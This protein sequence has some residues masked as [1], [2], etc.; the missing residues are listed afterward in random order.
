[1]IIEHANTK[2]N[3]VTTKQIFKQR[4]SVITHADTISFKHAIFKFILKGRFE[5]C[6]WDIELWGKWKDISLSYLLD[7]RTLSMVSGASLIFN[8]SKAQ[9]SHVLESLKGPTDNLDDHNILEIVELCLLGLSSEKWIH[10]IRIF[11]SATYQ[12]ISL[13]KIWYHLHNIHR[14]NGLDRHAEEEDIHLKG[15]EIDK[16]LLQL[17]TNKIQLL[18]KMPPVLVACGLHVRSALFSLYMDEIQKQIRS[19]NATI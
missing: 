18:W 2:H 7:K 5:N 15:R 19:D 14:E 13:S 9:W 10:L 16:Y 17:L 11:T 1:F 8:T 4:Q 12:V 6:A 3:N